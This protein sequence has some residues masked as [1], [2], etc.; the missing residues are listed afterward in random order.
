MDSMISRLHRRL[1]TAGL[2]V[3]VVALVLALTG[4]AFAASGAL[5]GKQKKEVEK[6]AKKYAGKQ[7]APG[8]AGPAGAAGPKGDI[9][10]AGQNGAAGPE[11][12]QG[13]PGVQGNPGASVTNTP[14]PTS[15]ATCNH[16]GGAEFK[17]GAGGPTTACNGNPAEYPETLP[18]GRSE[19]GV[20]SL[21]GFVAKP[22]IEEFFVPVTFPLKLSF[23]PSVKWVPSAEAETPG[24]VAGCPGTRTEPEAEAGNICFYAFGAT[25][26]VGPIQAAIEPKSGVILDLGYEGTETEAAAYG[27]W[28]VKAP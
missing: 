10:A 1:G 7:G 26:F 15:S 3:A 2:I 14:V 28:A 25:S 20:W 24:A 16:Q 22:G 4:A 11:G 6:I 13:I 17:V 9:G 23:T 8:A 12:K 27:T 19:T 21:P 18:S 5:T